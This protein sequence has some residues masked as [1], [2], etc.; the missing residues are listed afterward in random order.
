M[1]HCNTLSDYMAL[2]GR[3]R[4]CT[5]DFGEGNWR[6]EVTWRANLEETGWDEV[7][8]IHVM[9]VGTR[10]S[11]FWTWRRIFGVAL[12]VGNFLTG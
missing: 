7:A 10:G 2:N 8:W 1:V 11:L 5:E 9:Q 3:G 12:N 6:K 4:K